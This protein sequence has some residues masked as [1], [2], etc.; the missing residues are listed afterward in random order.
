[1]TLASQIPKAENIDNSFKN[2][3]IEIPEL[4][5]VKNFKVVGSTK[6]SEEELVAVTKPFTNRAI[7]LS[8]LPQFYLAITELYKNK[9][10]INFEAY[11]PPQKLF[12]ETVVFKVLENK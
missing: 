9:G 4:I 6:F 7:S 8:E 3:S 10:Y 11:I 1:M 12:C 2:S 5:T